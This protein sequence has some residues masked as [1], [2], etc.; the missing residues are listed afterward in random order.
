MKLTIDAI[1]LI[2][3]TPEIWTNRA[4]KSIPELLSDHA[5]C[6]KK[7]A[8]MAL[9]LMSSFHRYPSV[10]EK[11]SKI[12]REE[13]VHYEQVLKLHTR[14]G[15]RFNPKPAGR[16][17]KALWSGIDQSNQY[18]LVDKLM[19]AAIIE[20]RS[21]ERFA[22]LV[23]VLS[24][25]LSSYYSRLYEAEKR[26]ALIYLEFAKMISSADVIQKRLDYFLEIESECI[27]APEAEF[28]FH[29]GIPMS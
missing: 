22:C 18:R 25:P 24:D 14:L 20:A 13:L 19:I 2:E 29:S 21:C 1:N 5:C 11:L 23:P 17:A 10:I 16:Y 6:E 4:V 8:Q 27:M 28:R 7:A 26:H 12:A 9:S 3:P 15:I